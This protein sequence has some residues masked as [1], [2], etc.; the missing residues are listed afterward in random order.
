[1]KANAALLAL[2]REAAAGIPPEVFD[3]VVLQFLNGHVPTRLAAL[4]WL[5]LLHASSSEAFAARLPELFPALLKILSD[6]SDEVVKQA[7]ELLALIGR[8]RTYFDLLMASLVRLFYS[9]PQLL[10]KRGAN[11]IRQLALNMDAEQVFLALAKLVAASEEEDFAAVMIT[12]MNVLLLTCPEFAPLRRALRTLGPADL[13][14]SPLHPDSQPGDQEMSG[15]NAAALFVALYES[16]AHNPSCLLAL[17]LAAQQYQHAFDLICRFAELEITVAFL[18]E[19]DKLVQLL[20]SPIFTSLRLQLLEPER[21]PALYRALYGL[22]MLLPQSSAY[23]TLKSRL[24]CL[25]SL[26]VLHLIPPK[27]PP[28]NPRVASIDFPRLLTHFYAVQARHA[29]RRR[30]DAVGPRQ[31]LISAK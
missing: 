25:S 30:R 27:L 11:T 7:L 20:E 5:K 8:N 21:Y 1:V 15:A 22:L 13:P 23:E 28:A 6:P 31:Q 18:M 9:D 17:C 16:W 2:V 19:I 26:G 10:E 14:T 24:N 4:H 29:Q 12:T 3:T